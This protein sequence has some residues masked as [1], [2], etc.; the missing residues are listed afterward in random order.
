MF[1]TASPAPRCGRDKSEPPLPLALFRGVEGGLEH[2][3]EGKGAA[4]VPAGGGEHLDLILR[5]PIFS[6]SRVLT[7]STTVSAV[8][9]GSR[10]RRKKKSLYWF[11][12]SGTSPRS[13]R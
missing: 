13:T 10:R 4:L 3:V 5:M 2:L 1:R 9:R 6:G 8:R 12:R 11:R 7:S